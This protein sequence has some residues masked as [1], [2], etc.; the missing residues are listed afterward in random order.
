MTPRNTRDLPLQTALLAWYRRCGRDL[1]WRRTG[2]PYAIL[3]SEVMLQQTQVDR[4]LPKYAEFMSAYPTAAA[5][6]AA[7]R[8][9][10]IRRWAPLGYNLRAVRLHEIARQVTAIYQGRF[11]ESVEGL[12]SL[13]GIGPYT[14]GALA[15]FAFRQ[16]VAFLDTNIRRV[17]GRSLLGT[18]F[19]RSGDDRP[20]LAAAQAALPDN[21][22]DWHQALMDLGATVCA[23]R[24]PRCGECP[25]A[26][27][28]IARAHFE[29]EAAAPARRV[30]EA[31]PGYRTQPKFAGSRRYYRG[32][33]V[34]ALRALPPGQSMPLRRL[35][36][37]VK[38]GFT[39]ADEPWLRG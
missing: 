13:K 28:C 38:P 18:P 15:C 25:I 8:S 16:R 26:T 29:Q 7:P 32:R 9:E 36:E 20:V 21:A 12:Q 3:V 14:A 11:P 39:I 30:A 19:P 24:S 6:A 2:D 33:I 31:S 4:V 35:G 17:V 5:L 23:W 27:W 22:Y 10:V 34:A 1:P 37:V